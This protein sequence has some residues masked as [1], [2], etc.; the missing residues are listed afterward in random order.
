MA[1]RGPCRIAAAHRAGRLLAPHTVERRKE[2]HD[3]GSCPLYVRAQPQTSR[4]PLDP[5]GR[6]RPGADGLKDRRICRPRGVPAG[7]GRSR[8]RT[9][10]GEADG[11]TGSALPPVHTAADLRML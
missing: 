3:R 5:V 10:E 2:L 1:Y 6:D 11:F 9:W 7:G 8:I 4:T